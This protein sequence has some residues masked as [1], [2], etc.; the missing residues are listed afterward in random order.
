MTACG[1]MPL[2]APALH[3]GPA[4]LSLRRLSPG[5]G[6]GAALIPTWMVLFHSPVLSPPCHVRGSALLGLVSAGPPPELTR[7]LGT[8]RGLSNTG[9]KGDLNLGLSP[10]GKWTPGQVAWSL[11]FSGS[12]PPCHSLGHWP[13]GHDLGLSPWGGGH[14]SAHNFRLLLTFIEHLPCADCFSGTV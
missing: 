2:C 9:V 12:W 10:S 14:R 11:A 3:R 13:V 6:S 8:R 4:P 7:V 1:P 5:L